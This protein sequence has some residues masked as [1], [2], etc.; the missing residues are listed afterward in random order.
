MVSDWAYQCERMFHGRPSGIDNSI[1]TFG[2]AILFK[3]GKVVEQKLDVPQIPIIL[4]Y[5][6]VRRN[7]KVLVESATRRRENFPKVISGTMD[8]IDAISRAA[9]DSLSDP[10][11][12]HDRYSLLIDMNQHLLNVLGAGHDSIDQVV[13]IAKKYG[14][15]TK[16]TG[17]GGGGCVFILQNPKSTPDEINKLKDELTSSNFNIWPVS[18]G[19]SGLTFL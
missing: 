17:A 11:L 3:E 16:L 10:V 4:V 12:N 15:A 13:R 19:G 9:W 6:N 18:L 2:G 14:C 5:T 7:T 8:A 1:C